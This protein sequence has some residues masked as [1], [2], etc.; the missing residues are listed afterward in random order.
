MSFLFEMQNWILCFL[1]M[2]MQVEQ[3]ASLDPSLR[4]YEFAVY[5][6]AKQIKGTLLVAVRKIT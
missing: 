5:R 1:F 4:W 2:L 6:E 3:C